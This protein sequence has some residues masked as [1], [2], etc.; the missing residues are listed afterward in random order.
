MEKFKDNCDKNSYKYVG[1]T[2]NYLHLLRYNPSVLSYE[3]NTVMQLQSAFQRQ[4]ETCDNFI[5]C[6]EFICEFILI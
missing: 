2:C 6:F 5:T 3:T 1:F 4:L